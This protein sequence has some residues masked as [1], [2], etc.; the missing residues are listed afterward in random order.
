MLVRE[1][2]GKMENQDDFLQALKDLIKQTRLDELEELKEPIEKIELEIK[3]QEEK[4]N[5]EKGVL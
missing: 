3:E 5:S 4:N 1:G 2:V